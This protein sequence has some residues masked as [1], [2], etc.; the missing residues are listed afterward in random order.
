MQPIPIT[1]LAGSDHVAGPLPETGANLHPLAVY[2]GAE[3]KV[4]ER[5]LIEVL[6]DH[7][8]KSEAFGPITIAGP[9]EVYAHLGLEARIVDTSGSVAT[10]LHAAIDDHEEQHGQQPMAMIA[11][12]VILKPS[13]LIELR[14]QYENDRPCAMWM[15]F[16]RMP[17]DKEALGSFAWKPSYS[18]QPE[19]G[20]EPFRILPGH[21]A[22]FHPETLR[23]PLLYKLLDLA[24]RTRNHPVAP[25]R[26]LMIR[27]ILADLLARD[28]R[29]IG[30][31]QRPRITAA[32]I[33]NGLRLARGLRH[34]DITISG[35]EK[36]IGGIF[37]QHN[38]RLKGPTEGIRHPI[39]DILS[40]AEDVDTEEEARE[41]VEWSEPE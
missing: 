16:V 29:L 7:I 4:G 26:R 40:L 5:R 36:A 25:R 12:D 6:F 32:V 37:L 9:A 20:G 35:L 2:K 39:V 19:Q 11:Y 18:L 33:S 38:S 17:Q 34:G 10:N 23:L 13:E 41:F 3:V 22:I 28:L 1:I 30:S 8:V 21:L 24:Y 31:L 15:P 27:S 14:Q